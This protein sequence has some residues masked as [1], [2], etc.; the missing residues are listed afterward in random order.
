MLCYDT[1]P[2]MVTHVAGR[3]KLA[4]MAGWCTFHTTVFTL[5]HMSLLEQFLQ[6]FLS[7]MLCAAL[8]VLDVGDDF[9]QSVMELDVS[10][11]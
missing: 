2:L 7:I 10:L 9:L 5:L 11:L 8:G 6:V 4:A 1:Q 3:R